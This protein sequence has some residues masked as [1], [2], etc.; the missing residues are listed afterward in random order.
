MT[1]GGSDA[2]RSADG[3]SSTLR[4]RGRRG[5]TACRTLV[6]LGEDGANGVVVVDVIKGVKVGSRRLVEGGSINDDTA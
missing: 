3:G 2:R 6:H 5:S 1:L 4:R